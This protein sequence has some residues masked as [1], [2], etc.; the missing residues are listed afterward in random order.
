VGRSRLAILWLAAVPI[1]ACTHATSS[2]AGRVVGRAFEGGRS[3]FPGVQAIVELSNST[4]NVCS[5]DAYRVAWRSGLFNLYGGSVIC[6]RQ[7][8][9]LPPHGSARVS[10]QVSSTESTFTE[11]NSRVVDIESHCDG[12]A[13]STGSL[14]AAISAPPIDAASCAAGSNIPNGACATDSDCVLT[15]LADACD[16]CNVAMAYVTRKV[17]LDA[18]VAR[19]ATTPPCTVGCPPQDRYIPSFYRAECRSHRCIAWRYH[20]GG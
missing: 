15:D 10:C 17:T 9:T 18:H 6:D 5:I 1:A 20:G 7:T 4:A 11:D 3:S 8:T 13:M 2:V 14:A 12:S 19:C 16:A